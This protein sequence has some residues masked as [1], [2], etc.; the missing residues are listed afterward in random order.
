MYEM[1]G[2]RLVVQ[3]LTADYSTTRFPHVLSP[4][5]DTR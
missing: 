5:Q 3:C 4:V 2:P 1:Q